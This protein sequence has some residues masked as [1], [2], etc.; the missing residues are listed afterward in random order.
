MSRND[1]DNVMCTTLRIVVIEV[2]SFWYPYDDDDDDDNYYYYYYY[3][4][5][6]DDDEDL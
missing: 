2:M 4:I 6:D 5:K 3:Y 1:K